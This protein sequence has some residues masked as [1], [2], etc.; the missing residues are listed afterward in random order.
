MLTR[1]ILRFFDPNF[2][3]GKGLV[4]YLNLSALVKRGATTDFHALA[5]QFTEQLAAALRNLSRVQ[6]RFT[7]LL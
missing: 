4:R 6:F 7:K 3:R 5:D 1:P 2:L